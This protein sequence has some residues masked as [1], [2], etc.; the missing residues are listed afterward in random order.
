MLSV[1]FLIWV[2]GSG[3]IAHHW[4]GQRYHSDGS[5]HGSLENGFEGRS[6]GGSQV[7]RLL[8]YW[9]W[10][11]NEVLNRFYGSSNFKY[12]KCSRN[13]WEIKSAGCWWLMKLLVRGKSLEL[14]IYVVQGKW[15]CCWSH[16]SALW[17]FE[18]LFWS[19]IY[20]TWF[21]DKRQNR[22]GLG[23]STLFWLERQDPMFVS[24]NLIFQSELLKWQV[25][26]VGN[27]QR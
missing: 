17:L 25:N 27:H 3:S 11:D 15:D 6:G 4:H 1:L 20:P 24:S 22:D 16:E 26:E 9:W 10:I 7:R 2:Q 13:I 5:S 12:G 21:L 19:L 18:W 23:E 14:V 8:K